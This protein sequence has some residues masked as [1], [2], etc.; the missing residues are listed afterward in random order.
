MDKTRRA[1]IYMRVARA[2]RA[3]IY[4]R[5]AEPNAFALKIQQE[6]LTA[7]A[8]KNHYDIGLIASVS[9]DDSRVCGIGSIYHIAECAALIILMPALNNSVHV[10]MRAKVI[11]G[12]QVLQVVG[13]LSARARDIKPVS[14]P[15]LHFGVRWFCASEECVNFSNQF[16]GDFLVVLLQEGLE[17]RGVI[18][19]YL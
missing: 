11:Q 8:E 18:I 19:K 3:W 12:V 16:L 1:A 6:E 17:L 10:D 15:N 4:C 2:P 9:D 14:R 5:T 7:F 13:L